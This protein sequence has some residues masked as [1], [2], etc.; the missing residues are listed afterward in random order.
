MAEP[1]LV[2]F[3]LEGGQVASPAKGVLAG[4]WCNVALNTLVGLS[5]A[6]ADKLKAEPCKLISKGLGQFEHQHPNSTILADGNLETTCFSYVEPSPH[7]ISGSQ[8]SA[9]SVDCK[10][11]DATRVAK[12]L[13]VSTNSSMTC[14]DVN[15]KAVEV[16]KGLLPQKSL[17]RYMERGRGVCFMP[18]SSVLGN[19]G[20]L[21]LKSSIHL[22]ETEHCLQVTS[23]ALLSDINS[24]IY[25][26]NHYCKLFSPA[27]ALDWIMTDSH[28]PFPYPS[29]SEA[30][31]MTKSF[32][33]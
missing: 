7:S 3:Q 24:L 32:V 4:P 20:P 10:S 28:K 22:T 13:K 12:Q 18:D 17:R 2:A 29:T 33:I 11:I 5:V 6:D 1:F 14:A 19:I 21:W 26:G 9:S 31:D 15:R 16:A 30:V 25:P 23:S 8:F 27:A